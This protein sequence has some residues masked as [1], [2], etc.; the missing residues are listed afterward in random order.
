MIEDE[1]EKFLQKVKSDPSLLKKFD[2]EYWK[3]EELALQ[4]FE[5][6]FDAVKKSGS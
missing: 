1:Y 5:K 2:E 4:I 3:E 6:V